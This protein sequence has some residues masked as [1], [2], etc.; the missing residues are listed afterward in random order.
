MHES[1]L[2]VTT[3]VRVV[4]KNVSASPAK[5]PNGRL[6]RAFATSKHQ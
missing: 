3:A 2:L 4:G 1:R 5:A 6:Y